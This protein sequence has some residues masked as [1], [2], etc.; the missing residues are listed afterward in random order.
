M[1]EFKN[2]MTLENLIDY[3]D[4][5][6]RIDMSQAKVYF[7]C[8]FCKQEALEELQEVLCSAGLKN[9]ENANIEFGTLVFDMKTCDV[10]CC[11]RPN[12]NYDDYHFMQ[13]EAA[14]VERYLPDMEYGD[15]LNAKFNFIKETLR[16]GKNEVLQ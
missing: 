5:V 10:S 13:L 11:A 12:S 14:M 2:V 16:G 15:Y 7:S 4:Q 6:P 9:V 1:A 8:P 3:L